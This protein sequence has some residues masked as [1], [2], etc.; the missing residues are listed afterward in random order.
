MNWVKSTSPGLISVPA[1]VKIRMF[2]L[3]SV[4][5]FAFSFGR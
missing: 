1:R 2:E 5:G 3:A 4:F